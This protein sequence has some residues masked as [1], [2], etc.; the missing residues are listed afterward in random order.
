MIAESGS[1][2]LYCI[3][4]F[5]ATPKPG[6]VPN[7]TVTL[8][9][10]QTVTATLSSKLREKPMHKTF[11]NSISPRGDKRTTSCWP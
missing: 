8:V 7:Q 2:V 1:C 9:P 10:N 11:S 4:H 6:W 3:V 5:D